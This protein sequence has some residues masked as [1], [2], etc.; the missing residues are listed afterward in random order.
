[1]KRLFLVPCL[2]VCPAVAFGDGPGP[3]LVADLGSPSALNQGG[4]VLPGS[5]QPVGDLDVFANYDADG[6]QTLWVTDGTAAGTAELLGL[7]G[8]LVG[9]TG[10]IGYYVAEDAVWRTD[11]TESGTFPVYF[12]R[13]DGPLVVGDRLFFHDCPAGFFNCELWETSDTTGSARPL[14]SVVVPVSIAWS[15]APGSYVFLNKDATGP[16]YSVWRT[17]GTPQGTVQVA[18]LGDQILGAVGLPGGRELLALLGPSGQELWIS[19]GTASGTSLLLTRNQTVGGIDLQ[20]GSVLDG[21]AYFAISGATELEIW[22]SDGTRAGT[23]LVLSYPYMDSGS[24]S[25]AKLGNR[26]FFALPNAQAGTVGLWSSLGDPSTSAPLNCP[27]CSGIDGGWVRTIGDRVLFAAAAGGQMTLWA[28][29]ANLGVTSVA[30]L[31]PTGC[32]TSGPPVESGSSFYFYVGPFSPSQTLWKTDGT[33]GGTASVLTFAISFTGLVPFPARNLLLLPAATMNSHLSAGLQLWAT[34][35]TA[36]STLPLTQVGTTG[37]IPSSITP[38]GSR[39]VFLACGNPPGLW[40]AGAADATLALATQATLN[41]CLDQEQGIFD[42]V[43]V[44]A[45]AFFAQLPSSTGDFDQVWR[46]HGDAA[47]TTSIYTS[48][49]PTSGIDAL[50]DFQG[51]LVFG[52]HDGSG[53][54]LWTSDGNSTAPMLTLPITGGIYSLTPAGSRLYFFGGDQI[55]RTDGS[56]AGTVQL[57]NVPLGELTTVPLEITA[58][59]SRVF[60]VGR[61]GLWGTDGTPAGT[62]LL[63]PLTAGNSNSIDSLYGLGGTMIFQVT[64]DGTSTLWRTLGTPDSTQEIAAV[65]VTRNAA[66]LQL[67]GALL[68]GRLYFA[69]D[70]GVHG[71]ELWRTDGT[72]AGTVL[73]KDIAPGQLSSSV[74]DLVSF[75]GRVY[76]SAFTPA[77]GFE[78]WQSDG[79]ETG[80]QLV[81]DIVPGPMSSSPT[82]LTV[83]GNQLFFSAT[84]MTHGRQLW[85]YLPFALPAAPSSLTASALSPRQV[86]LRWQDNAG[87][88]ASFHIEMRIG[89]G[90]QEVAV[91]PAGTTAW[92]KRGLR[93]HTRYVFRVR[94]E[95]TAGFSGYSNRASVLT[96]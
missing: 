70:D 66:S 71:V 13:A 46:T 82:D 61:S 95:N 78:L 89:S 33:P 58:A 88:Q 63:F 22:R 19:D 34:S 84:N 16:A 54:R 11:G 59:A 41:N 75:G 67:D 7:P 26:L 64:R 45:N 65:Q 2:L 38:A 90:F 62:T 28:I 80:T 73:V 27:V 32:S 40:G 60:F 92:V 21:E 12:G 31:C 83:A 43:S 3:H 52:E 29:D 76:F 96:P 68:D 44:G 94:A 30:D 74:H 14:L 20:S 56:V 48:G 24:A 4:V 93:P 85:V 53:E 69:A 39:V 72:A 87:G 36:G 55:W 9:S 10:S 23:S 35:G 15:P 18:E 37:A 6:A 5:F 86:Q 47:S 77:T 57:T 79:T 17:D 91:V 51:E 8:N 49:S 25:V 1:M 50:A 81:A 42:L